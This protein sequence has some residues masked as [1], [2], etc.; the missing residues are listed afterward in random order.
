MILRILSAGIAQLKLYPR[1]DGRDVRWANIKEWVISRSSGLCGNSGIHCEATER[2][3]SKTRTF[4]IFSSKLNFFPFSRR[5]IRTS[6]RE[7]PNNGS[8]LLVWLYRTPKTMIFNFSSL[9]HIHRWSAIQLT[10][11]TLTREYNPRPY[12]D[13]PEDSLPHFLHRTRHCHVRP[14][15]RFNPQTILKRALKK[16]KKKKKL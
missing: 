9:A 2:S 16:K 5:I 13:F 1:L 3:R 6:D 12:V 15:S 11:L 4:F 14:S 7:Q 8:F 10:R